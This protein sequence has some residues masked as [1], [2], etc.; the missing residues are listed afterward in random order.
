MN[1][2]QFLVTAAAAAPPRED[3][4]RVSRRDPHYLETSSGK[5]YIPN[6]LNLIAPGRSRSEEEGFATFERWL[7]RLAE[8]RANYIRLWLSN[9]F[10]AVEH[11]LEGEYD[12]AKAKRIERAL[13]MCRKRGIYAKL[14]LEHFRT[15]GEKTTQPWADK[16]LHNVANGGSARSI[17]DFFDG[18]APRAQFRKKIEWFAKRFGSDP[19]VYGWELWNEVNATRGGDVLAWTEVMLKELRLRFPRNMAMQSLGSFDRERTRDMYRRHSLM[20]GNDLAQ[21]HRYLDLGAEWTVCHGPVDV[22]AAEAVRE[23]LSYEPNKPVILAESG[24]VE[25]KHTGPFKFYATDR[26]GIILH[27]VLFAPFFA[28][29]AGSGQIW[30][31]DAYVD[32]NNLWHHFGRFADIAEKL[33]PASE[34]FRPAM[35]DHDSLRI[36]ALHGKR[37]TLAWCR[38]RE[39]TWRSELEQ[40]RPPTPLR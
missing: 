9:E 8:N 3:F 12:E 23:L 30:H 20:P 4:I 34:H 25:P 26:A 28:G 36:Y 13:A 39:N 31:W 32:K 21:A 6:G 22:L 35:I 37:T 2:R 15:I 11:A 16:P 5:P 40:E 27:D 7:D 33:D 1:R 38:D 14:T 29:A 24:A 18:E 19:T 17:A 10:W